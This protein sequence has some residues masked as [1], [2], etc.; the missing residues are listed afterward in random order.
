MH[1]APRAIL[2]W[3]SVLKTAVPHVSAL[4]DLESAHKPSIDG[5]RWKM[6]VFIRHSYIFLSAGDVSQ[7]RTEDKPR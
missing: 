6:V 3:P 2:D 7:T 4:E 5:H 1:L